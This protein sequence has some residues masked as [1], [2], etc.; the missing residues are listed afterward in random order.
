MTELAELRELFGGHQQIPFQNGCWNIRTKTFE[1]GLKQEH[2]ALSTLPFDYQLVPQKNINILA[3]KICSWLADRVEGS[4]VFTNV[5][6]AVIF[7]CILQIQHP[8]RFLF[9]TGHSATG[10]STFFLLLT[11]VLSENTIYTVSAED[12]GCD[13]GLED[14][15]EGAKK[16]VILFHDIGAAVT[17]AFINI[18]RTLVSSAGETTHKR[19]RRK[20]KRTGFL[21]FSGFICAAS[22]MAPFTNVQAEGIIDRR[23]ILVPFNNRVAATHIQTFDQMFAPQE[24]ANLASFATSVAPSEIRQFLLEVSQHPEIKIL[25][26]EH[27]ADTGATAILDSFITQCISYNVESWIPYGNSHSSRF[28]ILVF[29]S[30]V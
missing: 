5:L 26:E 2:F 29:F 28:V 17:A 1:N 6:M 21:Q 10:K 30:L 7:A 15:S 12:F 11:K 24:L 20:H 18:L 27:Y 3:P 16:A 9:L 8:E 14:L 4:E 19:V 25:I 23:L 22:N 13:F